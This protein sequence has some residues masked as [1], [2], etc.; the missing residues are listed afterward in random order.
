[1]LYRGLC[2]IGDRRPRACAVV[3]TDE[4]RLQRVVCDKEEGV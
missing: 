2:P 3:S 4:N 1:M